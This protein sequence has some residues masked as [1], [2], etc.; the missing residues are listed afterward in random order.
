MQKKKSEIW[1]P[2]ERTI[3][4]QNK[5][6]NAEAYEEAMKYIELKVAEFGGKVAEDSIPSWAKGEAYIYDRKAYEIY[7]KETLGAEAEFTKAIEAKLAYL[8]SQN[9]YLKK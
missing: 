8:V 9:P 3:L 1:A 5:K 4:E 2:M 6:I 7:K